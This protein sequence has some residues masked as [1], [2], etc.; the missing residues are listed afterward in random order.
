MKLFLVVAGT[1]LLCSS[2]FATPVQAT[3]A[4]CQTWYD[5]EKDDLAWIND[6]PQCPCRIT[7]NTFWP[8]TVRPE[9]CALRGKPEENTHTTQDEM[10]WRYNPCVCLVLSFFEYL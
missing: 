10:W 6:L 8:C 7:T 9:V 1:T 2:F 4:Q 5:G 3:C